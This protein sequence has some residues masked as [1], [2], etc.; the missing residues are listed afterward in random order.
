MALAPAL[1]GGRGLKRDTPPAQQCRRLHLAPALRGGR[2]LKHALRADPFWQEAV[3]APALRGGRGLKLDV[4]RLRGRDH[5][6]GSR[7]SGRE[8]IET[9]RSWE[10]RRRRRL[11]PALRGGRGLKRVV[12]T[13]L[14]TCSPLAPALRGGRGLKRADRRGWRIDRLR[15][16][17]PFGAG[18]D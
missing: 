14:P 18:E 5:P 10:R 17:P 11:A 8:R 12:P 16:L 2:G 7:P 15:W 1:R 9:R 4:L 6:A 3:L 13:R